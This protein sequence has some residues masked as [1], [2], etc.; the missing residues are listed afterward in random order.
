MDNNNSAAVPASGGVLVEGKR[1]K[2]RAHYYLPGGIYPRPVV[3]VCHGIPGNERL[4]D[5]SIA[6]R[7]AGFCTVNFH[8]SFFQYV[9]RRYREGCCRS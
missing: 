6:L 4:F 3:L 7:E 8:Y 5:F 2:L 9:K 1:G